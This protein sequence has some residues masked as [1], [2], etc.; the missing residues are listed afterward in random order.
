M[1]IVDVTY[2]KTKSSFYR[3]CSPCRYSPGMQCGNFLSENK[4]LKL[5]LSVNKLMNGTSTA[6]IYYVLSKNLIGQRFSLHTYRWTPTNLEQI[7]SQ[8]I[9]TAKKYLQG[10]ILTLLLHNSIMNK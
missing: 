9:E 3:K 5:Q 8:I 7:V 1:V 4:N 6:L 10:S 2:R